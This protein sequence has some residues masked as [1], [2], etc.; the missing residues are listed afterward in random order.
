MIIPGPEKKSK[1]VKLAKS[2]PVA[3]IA[4]EASVPVAGVP[5]K[6]FPL[7]IS[8]DEGLLA[9]LDREWHGKGFRSRSEAARQI[10]E[11]GLPK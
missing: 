9:R 3:A 8:V 1:P 7:T 5:I 10:L 2:K 6:Y 4:A 11:R